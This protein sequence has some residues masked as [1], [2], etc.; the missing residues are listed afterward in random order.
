MAYLWLKTFHIVGIVV[1]FSGLFYLVR[2][3]VYHAETEQHPEP[4][5]GILKQ[6]YEIMEKRLYNL[7]TTP[8]MM[9][10]LT[11]ALGIIYTEPEV[12]KEGWL[13]VKLVLVSGLIGY[14]FYCG[15]LLKQLA[16]DN[17]IWK[18]Q[19]FRILNEV[20]TVFLVAIVLLAVFKN[21]LPL[22]SAMSLLGSLIVV[23]IGVIHVYAKKR[24]RE[25]LKSSYPM[26]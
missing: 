24:L 5:R 9:V 19:Q 23:M 8:A 3:F 2:L 6:Q 15:W 11:M 26:L 4:A 20:P 10:A 16:K 13:Q 21:N 12:I 7:I 1:W 18:S 25:S 14:H 17:C 22:N